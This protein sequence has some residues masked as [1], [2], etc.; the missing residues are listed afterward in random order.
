MIT[1]DRRPNFSGLIVAS[2]CAPGALTD[3][4][5]EIITADCAGSGVTPG[6]EDL[7]LRRIEE[8]SGTLCA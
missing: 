2:N 3:S 5:R 8:S 7:L 4:S 6:I 1:V